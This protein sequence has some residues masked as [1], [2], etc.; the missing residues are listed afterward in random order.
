M[1]FSKLFL[2]ASLFMLATTIASAQTKSTN[3]ATLK[4]ISTKVKGITCSSDV[5]TIAGNVTKL[6]GVNT[7]KAEKAGP[8]TTFNIVYDPKLISEKEINA[9]IQNTGGC[10]NPNDKPYKVK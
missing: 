4:T 1:K 3:T 10:K 7:C 9:A 6:A 5:K 2:I 8:T